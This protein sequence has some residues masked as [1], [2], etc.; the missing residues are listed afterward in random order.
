M[1]IKPKLYNLLYIYY[2]YRL[3]TGNQETKRLFR[4]YSITYYITLNCIFMS[5]YVL[6]MLWSYRFENMQLVSASK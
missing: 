3:F 5:N 6:F 1:Y 2:N 4:C